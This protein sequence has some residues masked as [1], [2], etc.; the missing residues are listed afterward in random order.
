MVGIPDCADWQCGRCGHF[1][2]DWPNDRQALAATSLRKIEKPPR[3]RTGGGARRVEAHSP[4]PIAS[5]F[6]HQFDE[7]FIWTNQ[8]S[9]SNMHDLDCNWPGAGTLSLCVSWNAWTTG[10][11]ARSR[12]DTSEDVRI[13]GLGWRTTYFLG[14]PRADGPHCIARSAG[15]FDDIS[16]LLTDKYAI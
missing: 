5:A 13:L 8:N 9:V 15:S 6:S 12:T 11:E 7:L 2:F 3:A 1:I 4:Q 14:D 10:A 16:S